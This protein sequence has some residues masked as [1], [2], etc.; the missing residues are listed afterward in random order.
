MTLPS[1]FLQTASIINLFLILVEIEFLKQK[2]L[3]KLKDLR[4]I[5]KPIIPSVG[6]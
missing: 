3:H 1:S 6:P 5:W 4:E 2:T